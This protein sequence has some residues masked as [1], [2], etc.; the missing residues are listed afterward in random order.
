MVDIYYLRLTYICYSSTSCSFLVHHFLDHTGSTGE[1]YK[2]NT[3]GY[4]AQHRLLDQIPSLR[5]DIVIPDYCC[6]LL[7]KDEE[8][9]QKE[10]EEEESISGATATLMGEKGEV[11]SNA[12]TAAVDAD[13]T[14]PPP[15]NDVPAAAKRGMDAPNGDDDDVL[16]NAWLGP[17]G[18]V[19]PLHH[20]PYYN[21]LAQVSGK[22]C[23]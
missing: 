14:P 2:T 16:V 1:K 10:E 17:I 23:M 13:G 3:C 20:D 22:Y 4:L 15:R 12:S 18:T 5:K 9:A 11:S 21:L 7:D 8:E 6:L 19:S